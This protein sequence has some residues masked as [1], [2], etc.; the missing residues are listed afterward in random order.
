MPAC[1]C[2]SLFIFDSLFILPD[3]LK[4]R[5]EA[6][7]ASS[8][9]AAFNEFQFQILQ[10]DAVNVPIFILTTMWYMSNIKKGKSLDHLMETGV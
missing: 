8:L 10:I 2:S 1:K 5:Y 7:C 6:S 3:P 9:V 4:I